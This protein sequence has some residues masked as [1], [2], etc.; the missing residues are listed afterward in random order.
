M[1][2]LGFIERFGV[3]IAIARK[4]LEENGNPPLEFDV[5]EQHV[6]AIIK[7]RQ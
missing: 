2:S 1:L 5:R 7:A 4:A 6:L 3:G